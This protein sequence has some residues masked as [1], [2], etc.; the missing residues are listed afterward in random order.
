MADT[1]V[2]PVETQPS[3]PTL[4]P[5][6]QEWTQKPVQ[7]VAES[8]QSVKDTVTGAL[9]GFKWP[10][11]MDWKQKTTQPV[12]EPEKAPTKPSGTFNMTEYLDKTNKA[13]SSNNPYAKSKTSTATGGFQFI[14]RTWMEQVGKYDLPYT[15]KDRTDPEK[16]RDVAN[17][18]STENLERARKDLGRD[19]SYA[20][21]YAYHIWP[22]K[23]GKFLKADDEQ[24][25]SKMFSKA[26]T[27]ANKEIFYQ[28]EG[29]RLVP[30]TVGEVKQILER[31]MR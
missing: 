4:K 9:K 16:S 18:Y 2:K 10:W 27:Q 23:A 21:L 17:R 11:E 6:E 14:E 8:V 19:P 22:Y 5:W 31:K 25:A 3:V 20:E 28:K 13:E 1:E 30:R 26:I 15:L 24:L 7:A 29:R 12:S